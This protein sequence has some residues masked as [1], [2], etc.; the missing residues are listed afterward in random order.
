MKFVTQFLKATLISMLVFNVLSNNLKS[1]TKDVNLVSNYNN[2]VPTLTNVI[3]KAPTLTVDNRVDNYKVK[4]PSPYVHF[5]SSNT[6]SSANLGVLSNEPEIVTKDKIFFQ[7]QNSVPIVES[8]PA[9]LGFKK[10]EIN[11]SS[12]NKTTGNVE[13]HTST[14]IS[15]I[16]GNVMR[17]KDVSATTTQVADLNFMRMGQPVTEVHNSKDFDYNAANNSIY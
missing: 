16:Q 6:S 9:T 14:N 10:E 13:N 8:V 3:R 15:P 1:K 2:I 7:R 4:E 11:I 17:V 12:L 5:S